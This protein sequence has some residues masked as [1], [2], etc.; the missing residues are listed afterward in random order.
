[1][2]SLALSERR[3][4]PGHALDVRIATRGSRFPKTGSG[5]TQRGT[6]DV[7]VYS[8]GA[9]LRTRLVESRGIRREIARQSCL[10]EPHAHARCV[11]QT[12]SAVFVLLLVAG[13]LGFFYCLSLSG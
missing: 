12:D 7:R 6:H 9:E 8:R 2:E 4:R 5:Q 13:W 10:F 1:M 11:I 3:S